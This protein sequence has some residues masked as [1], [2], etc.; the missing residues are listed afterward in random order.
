M[1]RI[2][3]LI[4]F[5]FATLFAFPAFAQE[6]RPELTPAQKLEIANGI[7]AVVVGTV[8]LPAAILT[9]KKKELCDLLGGTYT[10][11]SDGQD[12]CPGGVWLRTIPYILEKKG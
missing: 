11:N 3:T 2:I 5:A 4:A 9:G 8:F 1:N 6:K 7:T 10:P 12:Q